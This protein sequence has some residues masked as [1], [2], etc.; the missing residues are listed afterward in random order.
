MVGKRTSVNW[1]ILAVLLA[2]VLSGCYRNRTVEPQQVGLKLKDGVSIQDV[3]G[4]GLYSSGGWYDDFV[5]VNG[6]NITT[7]WTD[8]SLVTKD[9]QPI[10]LTMALTF[11]RK[12]D[13]ESITGLYTRYNSEAKDD[14]ALT[15]LVLSK[16]PGVAKTIT[17]RYTLDQMLGIAEGQSAVGR[18]VLAQEVTTLLKSELD[19]VFVDLAS[20][21]IADIAVSPDFLAALNAKAQAQINM[22]V[23]NQQTKLLTEQLA[24]EKAQTEI[25][26][27][28]AR[29]DNLVNAETAKAY[30]ASP[31]LFDL[32][33]L[34]LLAN[35]L[36]EGDTVIYVPEGTDITSV[37]TQAPVVPVQ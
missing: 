13:K 10:G 5:T 14:A 32:R 17:T 18:E 25:S 8:P 15:N 11:S 3:V 19:P 29:R 2:L 9:K 27:E 35:V 12:R 20:V 24:Q 21:E 26:L 22:E 7:Q 36:G 28:K 4:P 1:T 16:V 6:S 34:E 33:K 37:L 30:D 23:A 31:E